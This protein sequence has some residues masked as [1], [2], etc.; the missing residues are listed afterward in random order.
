[1]NFLK[2]KNKPN[3]NYLKIKIKY[4]TKTFKTLDNSNRVIIRHLLMRL[5]HL[6]NLIDSF[7]MITIRIDSKR[8]FH[9]T[10]NTRKNKMSEKE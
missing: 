9:N 4:L 6:F 7:S 8:Q 5:A 1:M 2:K 10:L 3:N